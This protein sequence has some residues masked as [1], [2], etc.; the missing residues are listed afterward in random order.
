[1]RY[2]KCGHGSHEV[3]RTFRAGHNTETVYDL[4][5]FCKDVEFFK[6]N[7]VKEEILQELEIKR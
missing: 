6:E 4:C 1:M 2:E 7:I 5:N 3:R